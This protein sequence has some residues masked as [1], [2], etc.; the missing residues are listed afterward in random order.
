MSGVAGASKAGADR[1]GTSRIDSLE[2][3]RGFACT[4]LLTFHIVRDSTVR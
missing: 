2:T 4:L 3:L 1:H